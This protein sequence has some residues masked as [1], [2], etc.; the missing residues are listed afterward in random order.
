[1]YLSGIASLNKRPTLFDVFRPRT[2]SDAKKKDKDA[3]KQSGSTDS[4]SGGSN[5]S[6]SGGIMQSMKTA[7]QHTVGHKPVVSKEVKD[8][9]AHPHA[10]SDKQVIF[11][12]KN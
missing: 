8:G 5:H 6:G 9:S 4:G 1:M 2:K 11:S 7:I 12:V 10:G 3:A